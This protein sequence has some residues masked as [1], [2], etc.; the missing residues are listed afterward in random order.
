MPSSGMGKN[1]IRAAALFGLS[2]LLVFAS[3]PAASQTLP[4]TQG[5][6]LT[7]RRVAPADAVRNHPAILI[8]AFSREAGAGSADWEKAIHADPALAGVTVIQMAMLQKAPALLRGL[9]KSGMRKGLTPAQQ[10]NFIVLI[11]DEELW[12]SYFG[13]ASEKDSCVALLDASGKLRW[14]AQGPPGKLLT[15]LKSALK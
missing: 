8:A 6:T 9:I 7:G 11:Q 15:Q 5:E 13:I 2:A 1:S 10:D 4:A 3:S 12:R 14:R